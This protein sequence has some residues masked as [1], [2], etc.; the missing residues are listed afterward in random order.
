MSIISLGLQSVGIARSSVEPDIEAELTK[1]SS[2]S[3]LRKLAEKD[4]NIISS[5]EKSLS[6][7]RTLLMPS[8]A[9]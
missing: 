2:V 4:P 7:V 5:V 9:V 8:C 1:C 6:P 3:Q